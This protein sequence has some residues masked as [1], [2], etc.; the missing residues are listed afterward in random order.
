MLEVGYGGPSV[1]ALP[2]SLA[3]A[4]GVKHLWS[5]VALP[6]LPPTL[7]R[8][9]LKLRLLCGLAALSRSDRR[10]QSPCPVARYGP[11][12]VMPE[13]RYLVVRSRSRKC[14]EGDAGSPPPNEVIPQS[15]EPRHMAC[16]S[17]T[18]G[19]MR[20]THMTW[21]QYGGLS[22]GGNE[23]LILGAHMPAGAILDFLRADEAVNA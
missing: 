2:R 7:D 10:S 5:R 14:K 19:A 15:F 4:A 16:H 9:H 13:G 12:E 21:A 23:I 6:P 18:A 17:R 20:G 11:A 3:L 22:I 8:A 1:A